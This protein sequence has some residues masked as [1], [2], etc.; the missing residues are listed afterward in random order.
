MTGGS[1]GRQVYFHQGVAPEKHRDEKIRRQ[2]GDFL[3]EIVRHIGSA[4]E[5]FIMGPGQARTELATLIEGEHLFSN[6]RVV[7]E[8]A[9]KLTEGQIVAQVRKHFKGGVG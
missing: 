3:D 4:D 7:V 2:I 5:L 8:P 1:R 9:D 6:C